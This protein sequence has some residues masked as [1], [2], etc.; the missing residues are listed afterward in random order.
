[1]RLAERG[2]SFILK[3]RSDLIWR[4]ATTRTVVDPFVIFLAGC[5]AFLRN[6]DRF[7]RST[8]RSRRWSWQV[9]LQ[10]ILKRT[11]AP[12]VDGE[13]LHGRSQLQSFFRLRGSGIGAAD[14]GAG[15]GSGRGRSLSSLHH[16]HEP[17][18]TGARRPRWLGDGFLRL[19]RRGFLNDWGVV[20]I[21]RLAN[22]GGKVQIR[23]RN[24]DGSGHLLNVFCNTFTGTGFADARFSSIT[25]A[26]IESVGSDTGTLYIFAFA[27]GIRSVALANGNTS[28]LAARLLDRLFLGHILDQIRSALRAKRVRALARAGADHRGMSCDAG[29]LSVFT[30][31]RRVGTIATALV[32]I[33][34]SDAGAL[35][36]FTL[37]S[38]IGSIAF[39]NGGAGCLTETLLH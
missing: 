28:G 39:A 23:R 27:G 38:W 20:G 35:S 21:H 31:A 37:A 1:M 14:I 29:A 34:G 22:S 6:I 5:N 33:V 2:F 7:D 36:I 26:L 25:L 32:E 19:D 4:A 13:N 9:C 30:F 8:N 11:P 16:I 24:G 10:S 15:G 3:M 17:A 12:R 18:R